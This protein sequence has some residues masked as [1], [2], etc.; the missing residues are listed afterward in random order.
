MKSLLVSLLA[1]SVSTGLC[2]VAC[3]G[4]SKKVVKEAG[5]E[6]GEGGEEAGPGAGGSAVGMAGEG[7]A[8]GA[9]GGAGPGAAGMPGG[10]GAPMGAGGEGGAAGPTFDPLG[11]RGYISASVSGTEQNAYVSFAAEFIDAP[12][13]AAQE[14]AVTELLDYITTVN[15]EDGGAECILTPPPFANWA[16]VPLNI[17]RGNLLTLSS[18]GTEITTAAPGAQDPIFYDGS[19]PAGALNPTDFTFESGSPLLGMVPDPVTVPVVRG[20]FATSSFTWQSTDATFPVDLVV[21][22][23]PPPGAF[24]AI[25]IEDFAC[26]IPIPANADQ[27]FIFNVP[28]MV[29]DTMPV[30]PQSSNITVQTLFVQQV[31]VS[32]GWIRIETS[33]Q[34][35]PYFVNVT[36]DPP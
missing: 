16:E 21:L 12:A 6:G 9:P 13:T 28:Q 17:A 20:G 7:G 1:L 11:Y 27:G 32:D 24:L 33:N 14:Q 4:D 18:D 3:E 23:T 34:F 15:R 22:G 2:V 36:I 26:R 29:V 10:A 8:P 31:P 35:E 25:Y 5:G 19:G 30:Y